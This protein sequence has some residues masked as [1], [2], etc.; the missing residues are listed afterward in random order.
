MY[1]HI[2]LYEIMSKHVTIQVLFYH[3]KCF[4]ELYLL[5]RHVHVP[6]IQYDTAQY[7]KSQN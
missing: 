3:I 6:S 5:C 2:P 4:V 1:A 7:E